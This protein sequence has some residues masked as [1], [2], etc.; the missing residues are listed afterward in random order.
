MKEGLESHFS[1]GVVDIDK[2]DLPGLKEE[3]QQE[4]EIENNVETQVDDFVDI[5]DVPET[6]DKEESVDAQEGNVPETSESPLEMIAE[7]H[8][9]EVKA[10]TSHSLPEG[11]DK[12]VEFMNETGG[13][14]GDYLSLNKDYDSEDESSLLREYYKK[15]KSNLDDEDIDYLINKRFTIDEED[16]DE[17]NVRDR[18][19]ARKE[20]LSNAKQYLV[21]QKDKYYKELKSGGTAREEAIVKAGQEANKAALQQFQD[22]TDETFKGF[23]GFVFDLGE[24]RK[25]VRY[26]VND[27]DKL[28]K[29]QSSLDEVFGKYFVDGNLEDGKGFHKAVFAAS[30][31]DN[32]ASLFYEQGYSQAVEE[33]Q[34]TSKNVDFSATKKAPTSDS[35]LSPGQ[36]REIQYGA[37][38]SAGKI[39]LKFNKF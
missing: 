30:N 12:L 28:K 10:S 14:L 6:L 16:D 39:N 13:N 1:E 5:G 24:K 31:A 35:K 11:V 26:R 4:Q 23:D 38:S 33:L 8:Q 2:R 25:P 20:E 9:D 36:A 18:K 32:I 27:V 22:K 29:S 34:K 19:I 17:D 15:T 21:G 3:L 7:D 37:E